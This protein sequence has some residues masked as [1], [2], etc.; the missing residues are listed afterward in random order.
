MVD[1][2]VND[3]ALDYAEK[4][5]DADELLREISTAN[6]PATYEEFV[7]FQR[8]LG[9]SETTVREQ[10]RRM[11]NVM[12]FQSIA[13]TTADRK[14]AATEA[15]TASSVLEKEGPK[16]SDQ[17]AKLQAKLSSM[18]RDERLASKRVDEQGLAI[19]QLRKLAPV[20]IDDKFNSQKRLLKNTI[21]QQISDA[22]IRINELECCLNPSRY[23]RES[24]YL[25]ALQRSFRDAVEVRASNGMGRKS[26]SSK[27]PSI[28]V[29]L[30][31]ELA[32]LHAKMGPLQAQYDS[33]LAKIESSLDY[34][35]R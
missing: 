31:R 24:D 6:R 8:E 19:E 28:R 32:E 25:D 3:I 7:Y 11:V 1:S 27:W 20:H 2:L 30:E 4:I 34:Y 5:I 13:G 12:R 16:I 21:R 10:L 9:W 17:I 33:E 35:A 14:A 29:E 23:P 22:E 15:A 18:E 26:H